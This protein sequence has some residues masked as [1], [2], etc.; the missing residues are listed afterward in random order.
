MLYFLFSPDTGMSYLILDMLYL[1]CYIWHMICDTGTWHDILNTRYLTPVLAMLIWHMISASI[2]AMLYLI[3]DIWHQ[4]LSCYTWHL[5]SDTGTCHAIFDTWYLTPVLVM[6]Y[7]TQ[8]S[9]TGTCH[10]IFDTWYLHRYLPCYIWYLI[11]AT[12]TCY[13]TLDTWYLTRY[14]T[15]YTWHLIS[16]TGTCHAILDTWYLSPVLVMLYLTLGIRHRYLPCN[17]WH[18]IYDNGTWHVILDTLYLTPDIW[19]LTINMLS[20]GTSTLDM[21]LWQLTSDYYTWHLYYMAYWWLS[22]LQRLGMI[23]ILLPDLW[24]TWTPM[25]LYSWTPILLN[26]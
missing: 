24:Y 1:P 11:S 15:C 22:L 8:I 3:L 13:A 10:T 5:I 7:L 21:I 26:S 9:D 6:L 12:I 23:I 17:T 14:L 18:M 4:Y 16:D 2:P 25:L 20:P 19:H